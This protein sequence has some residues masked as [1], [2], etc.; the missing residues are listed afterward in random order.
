[1][2]ER[3]PT[4]TLHLILKKAVLSNQMLNCLRQNGTENSNSPLFSQQQFLE[5]FPHQELNEVKILN[6]P[7]GIAG[8]SSA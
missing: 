5:A 8:L 4:E 7:S 6:S 3:E 1:M 2:L